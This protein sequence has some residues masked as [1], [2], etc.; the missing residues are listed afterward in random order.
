MTRRNLLVKAWVHSSS[1][2]QLYAESYV[3]RKT[4]HL[5]KILAR[6]KIRKR[7]WILVSWRSKGW[8]SAMSTKLI[9]NY[10]EG[11]EKR[12][13]TSVE[14]DK[15]KLVV[16]W[17]QFKTD[18]SSPTFLNTRRTITHSNHM[19][20]RSTKPKKDQTLLLST[21]KCNKQLKPK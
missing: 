14:R 2:F 11:K 4:K 18:T 12:T 17:K 16:R 21:I 15:R 7:K 6:R 13:K 9:A 3:R 10:L 8:L 1:S 5:L 19:L 20:C